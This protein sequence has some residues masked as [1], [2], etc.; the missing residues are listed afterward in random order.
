MSRDIETVDLA[1]EKFEPK[2]PEK[3][4]PIVFLHGLFGSKTNNRTVSK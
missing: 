1:Y 4:N 2:G 3:G